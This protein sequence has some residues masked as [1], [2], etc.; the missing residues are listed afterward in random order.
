MKKTIYSLLF[1]LAMATL[2]L[3]AQ[4]QTDSRNRKPETVVAD[5][6]AQLPAKTS[7]SYNR[8]IGEIAGTGAKGV[9]MLSAMLM[10]ASEADNSKAEYALNGVVNYVSA[11]DKANIRKPIH[12]ALKT[13]VMKTTDEPNRAFLLT[14]LNKL[15]DAS[16]FDFYKSLLADKY[17][18]KTAVAGLAKIPG[19]DSQLAV[20]VN[21]SVPSADLAY[22]A[23]CRKLSGVTPTLIKWAQSSD[24]AAKAAALNAL[25]V[26]GTDNMQSTLKALKA[27]DDTDAFLQLLDNSGDAK[28]V[29][30]EAKQLTKSDNQSLRCAGLRL[31]LVK[32]K[33]NA[34]KNIFAA[35]KDKNAQYRHTALVNAIPVLG[36]SIIP[37]IASDMKSLPADGQVDVMRWLGNN[38]AKGQIDLITESIGSQDKELAIASIES[39]GKIGGEKALSAILAQLSNEGQMANAASEALRTFNGNI[40]E[41]I[42]G[43]L[44]S[45]NASTLKE[46][47]KLASMR[48]INAA[49]PTVVKLTKSS[50]KRISDAAYAALQGT[51]SVNELKSLCG[52]LE[53]A[54]ASAVPQIQKAAELALAT[55]SG[56]EQFNKVNELMAGSHNPALYYPMLAQGGT[57]EAVAKLVEG[58]NGGNKEAAFNALLMVKNPEA[59]PTLY[60]IASKAS[61]AERDKMLDRYLYL[62]RNSGATPEMAYTLYSRAL[63]LKPGDAVRKKL[64]SALSASPTF[65]AAVLVSEY[66]NDP[67]ASFQAATA[68]EEIIAANPE[69]REGSLMKG[70]F[71]KAINIF[72]R[73][74]GK[75]NADAGY[76]IDRMNGFLADWNTDGGFKAAGKNGANTAQGT[77][78]SLGDNIENF[79]VV[80][81]WNGNGDAVMTVRSMPLLTLSAKNGISLAGHNT[82]V[83]ANDGWNNI[84]VRMVNDRLFVTA[85]GVQLAKNTI[86]NKIPGSDKAAPFKGAL[87]IA[88]SANAAVELRNFYADIMPDTPVYA[89]SDEEKAQGFELLFDGRSLENFHGNTSGY[90]PVDG[91][92]YVTAE[93]GGTGNLYTKKNYSDFIF[94]FEFFFD[95]P[96]V[97]NGIGIR[98]GKDVTGVDAAYDGMEI[99]ILDHDDPAYQGHN[100]GYTW[101]HPYQDHG[102]VYGVFVPKHINFGPIKQW[103]TEEIKAVGDHITVTVD[104]QIV[105][106]VNVR[107]AVKGHNV[108]PDGGKNNPYTLDHQNHPGLFNKEGYISFCG[109]GPGVKFRNVRVLDLTRKSPAKAKK[110]SKKK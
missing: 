104:G 11:A 33:A 99:Q 21:G 18:A 51:A 90:V 50:D 29:V 38:H 86:I 45:D 7:K 49:Y 91:N 39:A 92:I 71:D 61:G 2:G 103:H 54:P 27:S 106:D 95:V 57:K 80:Y 85:N 93:Y 13:A 17:L 42:L 22:L 3:G 62:A 97:N 74:K 63:D 47:L 52:M 14:Q 77:S 23:Y 46:A 32:D 16:D 76:S 20:L 60:D 107:D 43:C 79:D 100:Y 72:G 82:V 53:T 83:P 36:E 28:T 9:E 1:L 78:I 96:A 108:A 5:A 25:A 65:P 84:E 67:A 105:T 89:L 19:I 73:E 15:A 44:S 56:T 24:A 109:H 102:G 12:D 48:H 34:R 40:S 55:L 88:S 10:P 75:G 70:N 26:C 6:M 94:R 8:L 87:N 31:L 68:F 98:T 110:A 101:L 59:L 30:K 41:G 69:L 64:V 81:D 58:Y 4:V 66:F 37:S 35:L